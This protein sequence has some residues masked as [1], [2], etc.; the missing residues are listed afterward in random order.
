MNDSINEITKKITIDAGIRLVQGEKPHIIA[1][2]NGFTVEIFGQEIIPAAKSRAIAQDEVKEQFSKTNDTYFEFKFVSVFCEDA[3]LTKSQINNLRRETIDKVQSTIINCYQ[4]KNKV[5]QKFDKTKDLVQVQGDF[6]EFSETFPDIVYD[7]VKN[8]VY[9]PVYLTFENCLKFY[10]KA[11]RQDNL[12]FIKPPI[13]ALEKNFANLEKIC[14]IFDGIVADNLSF[15]EL[16]KSLGKLIVAGYS[17]N[18]TNSK[19]LLINITNQHFASVELNKKELIPFKGA[20]LY[21]YGNLPL[22]HLNHCGQKCGNCDGKMLYKDK[23]GQYEITTKKFLGYC[24]H[25][26]KNGI[27][28]NL[29]NIDGYYKYFDFTSLEKT[30]IENILYKYY[31]IKNFSTEN[32]N[33][34]HLTRGV[35]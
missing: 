12:I 25:V 18:I 17:L 19:N 11:K 14:E 24:Q 35:N 29:G 30:E 6:A 5:W 31:I 28:T 15:V 16:G 33:H 1:S 21:T 26:L 2:A 27:V 9:N 23:K 7:N 3:F 32:Y 4:R 10:E 22:M 34:L 13:F 8:I 20:L